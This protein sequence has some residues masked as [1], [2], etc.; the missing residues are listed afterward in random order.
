MKQHSVNTIFVSY[1][2]HKFSCANFKNDLMHT[3]INS[4]TFYINRHPVV[5]PE[6]ALHNMIKLN[7]NAL[8]IP[9]D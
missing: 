8:S 9:N 3:L 1:F 7:R 4:A 5:G 6:F 2:Y